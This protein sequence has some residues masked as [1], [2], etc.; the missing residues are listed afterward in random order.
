MQ[1]VLVILCRKLNSNHNIEK[2]KYELALLHGLHG[3]GAKQRLKNV[4]T[5]DHLRMEIYQ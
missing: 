5:P 1:E 4:A 3:I 2:W